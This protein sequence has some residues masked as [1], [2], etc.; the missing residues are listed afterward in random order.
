MKNS[1]IIARIKDIVKNL[2]QN[3]KGD[4]IYYPEGIKQIYAEL[5]KQHK[6]LMDS[7]KDVK[8]E[9]QALD[10]NERVKQLKV[11]A[12]KLY[13]DIQNSIEYFKGKIQLNESGLAAMDIY[14]SND[15][16]ERYNDSYRRDIE[17]LQNIQE[18]VYGY[19]AST[20]DFSI[21]FEEEKSIRGPINN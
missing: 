1:R 2:S 11:F 18:F 16:L 10:F 5:E 3:L 6:E 15:E 4:T 20:N 12:E 17:E 14:V 19:V 21:K 9:S 7:Y 8:T 13:G